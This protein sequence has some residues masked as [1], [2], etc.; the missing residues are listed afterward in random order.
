MT[1]TLIDQNLDRARM[2]AVKRLREGG[3]IPSLLV[4]DGPDDEAVL[5]LGGH[6][7][8]DVARVVA[9]ARLLATAVRAHAFGLVFSTRL[10]DAA[11][12]SRTVAVTLART[13]TEQAMRVYD[14]DCAPPAPRLVEVVAPVAAMAVSDGACHLLDGLRLEPP[15]QADVDAAWRELQSMG[16]ETGNHGRA[17]H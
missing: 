11:K 16:I 9:K 10:V 17:M 12:P 4:I 7:R 8:D 2:L 13:R 15:S 3:P 6:R 1:A 5:R 14:I